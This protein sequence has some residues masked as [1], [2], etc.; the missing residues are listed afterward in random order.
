M[1][2]EKIPVAGGPARAR[3][4][5]ARKA[6]GDILFFTDADVT[7]PP[8]V[9]ERV[10]AAFQ[11]A[12]EVAALFGSYDDAPGEDN[13]LS[14]YKNLLHHYVHQTSKPEASTFWTGC[15]A[16]R[17]EIFLEMDGFD[18]ETYRYPSIE[19]IDLGYRL[20]KAGYRIRLIKEIQVKHW[21]RWEVISLL[22]A[23]FFYRAIPWTRLLLK[24]KRFVND[25]NI[26]TASRVS[27]VSVYLLIASLIATLWNPWFL[28][29]SV[30]FMLLLL[31]VNR[32][33]YRFFTEK[34]GIG[35]TLKT[36]PW[37]WLYFFYS[38]LAFAIGYA[39]H[40]VTN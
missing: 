28:S 8:D 5:G 34:R 36:I 31:L 23:D 30:G 13:L 12:P 15:G 6:R 27:V 24:E 20:K 29:P 1:R 11:E 17:R 25:L 19:D 7:L 33:L 3:N 21:K 14:Q 32:D 40:Q 2:V 38:G 18:G 22:K 37:H 16:I 35:F 26:N 39:R 10:A 9:I 4:L